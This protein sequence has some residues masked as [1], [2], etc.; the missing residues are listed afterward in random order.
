[1]NTQQ[2]MLELHETLKIVN[3]HNLPFYVEHNDFISA[4]LTITQ[5]LQEM[6]HKQECTISQAQMMQDQY[7]VWSARYHTGNI[8]NTTVEY[9]HSFSTVISLILKRLKDDFE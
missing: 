3:M 6:V 7:Q 9:S 2:E 8:A 5:E 1:M 4:D